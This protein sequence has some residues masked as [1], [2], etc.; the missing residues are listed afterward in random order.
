MAGGVYT[1]RHTMPHGRQE[2]QI[3]WLCGG[4]LPA[5]VSFLR[6]RK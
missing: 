6:R 4:E 5:N 2:W 3:G 1:P